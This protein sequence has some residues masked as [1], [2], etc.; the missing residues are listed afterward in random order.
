MCDGISTKTGAHRSCADY[1]HVVGVWLEVV[2]R[3]IYA[4]NVR[5]ETRGWTS[6]KLT[7][8]NQEPNANTRHIKPIQPGLDIQPNILR[9]LLPLPLQHTLGHSRHSRVVSLLDGLEQFREVPVIFVHL[10]WPV[11]TRCFSVIPVWRTSISV[12]VSDNGYGSVRG[13]TSSQSVF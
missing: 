7:L 12:S 8:P 2:Q 6:K 4:C 5:Y 9:V 10:W 1:A 3:H 11:D 13:F